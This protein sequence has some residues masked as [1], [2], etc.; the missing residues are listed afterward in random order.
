MISGKLVCLLP[1]F[2]SNLGH[3]ISFVDTLNLLAK[4]NNLNIYFIVSTI[5]KITNLD[6]LKKIIFTESYSISSELYNF[7]LNIRSLINFFKISN[8]KKKDSFYIDGYSFYFLFSFLIS[9]LISKKNFNIF[10]YCRYNYNSKKK[11]LFKI[12]IYLFKFQKVSL[13]ILTDNHPLYLI[14]KEDFKVKT[15]LMPIPHTFHLKRFE[16]NK[17]NNNKNINLLCPGQYREEKFGTNFNN[18]LYKNNSKFINIVIN[19]DFKKKSDLNINFK[20]FGSNLNMHEYKKLIVAADLILLPYEKT[21]YEFRT[22]GIFFEAITLQKRVMV[23]SGT[24]MADEFIKYDLKDLVV[25]DWTNFDIFKNMGNI[26]S[27]NVSKNLSRMRMQYFKKHN[28]NNFI[29]ILN[30]YI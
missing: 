29:K 12:F 14:L 23:T 21:L 4:K 17:F 19:K 3:E 28:K 1:S 27:S 15:L 8:I 18:F 24:W 6:N 11:F 9:C 26:F 7:Y 5:S 10:I 25:K 20:K 13:H 22:S 2:K 30:K 16:I